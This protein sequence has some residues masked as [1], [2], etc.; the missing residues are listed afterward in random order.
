MA[1]I[2]GLDSNADDINL[3]GESTGFFDSLTVT[4][5]GVG[6]AT[7]SST[8]A[9]DVSG[10]VNTNGGFYTNGT[11]VKGLSQ[12]VT[13]VTTNNYYVTWDDVGIIIIDS[14]ITTIDA[15]WLPEV[16]SP[17]QY[18]L[19]FTF[20]FIAPQNTSGAINC[21]NNPITGLTQN[22]WWGRLF[23]V[24]F[25]MNYGGEENQIVINFT[26]ISNTYGSANP[27]WITN[28]QVDEYEASIFH[29]GTRAFTRN[30]P[31]S[32]KPAIVLTNDAQFSI[33]TNAF[34]T[35]A[36]TNVSATEFSYLNG[37]SSNIQSQI[38]AITASS[39]PDIEVTNNNTNATYYPVFTDNFGT[40][41]IAYIDK[42][43]TPFSI[44][45]NKGNM[46]LANTIK[47]DSSFNSTIGAYESKIGIG[48]EA[49]ITNQ[50]IDTLAL[51]SY[52]GSINQHQGS[53][54]IGNSAGY[55]NQGGQCVALGNF[56]GAY[57]QA[58][59]SVCI[60]SN[61]G[62]GSSG[63]SGSGTDSII[64]NAGVASPLNNTKS[65]ALF[66]NPIADSTTDT[67]NQMVTYNAT[68]K[69]VCRQSGLTID[70]TQNQLTV[71]TF[72]ANGTQIAP[73]I[74]NQYFALPTQA[75]NAFTLYP[76]PYT[77]VIA[78]SW[79]V[80]T[81]SP[82]Y[83]FIAICKGTTTYNSSRVF[84]PIPSRN[85]YL[86]FQFS[87]SPTPASVTIS[88]DITFPST[89]DYLLTY[90][91]NGTTNN[92]SGATETLNASISGTNQNAILT[93]TVWCL[94]KML[95][96]VTNISAPITLTFTCSTTA[97]TLRRVCI[98]GVIITKCVGV[99]VSDGGIT[100]NQLLEYTGINT[101][102]IFNQTGN[103]INYGRT[104]LFG[105]LELYARYAPSTTLL[106]DS[107]YGTLPTTTGGRVIA[108]GNSNILS[109]LHLQDVIS[110]GVE[111]CQNVGVGTGSNASY[112]GANSSI[113][114]IGY[115][116]L[117]AFNGL[118][119]TSSSSLH[120]IF[121]GY[122]AGRTITIPTGSVRY[123]ACVGTSVLNGRPLSTNIQYNALFGHNIMGTTAAASTTI[124]YNS[125]FGNDSFKLAR[126]ESN[127]SVGYNNFN[128][129]TS[130]SSYNN[131][132]F[133]RSVCNN[134]TGVFD[135]QNCTFI[136]AYSD[137]P[138]AGVYLN[139]TCIGYAS[140]IEFS[141][142][143]F[144]GT[145]AEMTYAKGGLNIPVTRNLVLEGEL[146]VD[147][148][149]VAPN[150]LSFLSQVAANQIPTSAISGYGTFG[151]AATFNDTATFNGATT[152]FN[153]ATTFIL[154]TT[155]TD[156]ATFNLDL[157]ANGFVSF[158]NTVNFEAT[159]T[160]GADGYTI[161]PTQLAFLSQVSYFRLATTAIEDCSTRFPTTA[162]SL[163]FFGYLAGNTQYTVPTTGV[164]NVAIGTETLMDNDAGDYNTAVGS[165]AGRQHET[166]D[167]CTYVGYSAGAVQTGSNVTIV[168]ANSCTTQTS[169]PNATIIGQGNSVA[170]GNTNAVILGKGNTI[171][172]NNCGIIGY[173]ITNNTAN[174]IIIGNTSQ[175]VEIGGNLLTNNE[176]VNEAG[177][178]ITAATTIPD[179]KF[180]PYYGIKNGA[181]AFTI[182]LPT[183]TADRVGTSIK[184]RRVLGATLS[185]VITFNC[186]T[187]TVLFAA[188]SVTAQASI[189]MLGGSASRDFV[190]LSDGG[191][192]YGWYVLS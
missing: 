149:Y 33:E 190:C 82:T 150:Q 8:Y 76:S 176:Y 5:L 63:V 95:F 186:A 78:A 139:S 31:A 167:Y 43:T 9:I 44:N 14:R 173:G 46:N 183:A 97:T 64:I 49:G 67:A 108:I 21:Y 166:G 93:E 30:F 61:A 42:T 126:G 11:L 59:G 131:C 39:T 60:G 41:Q 152:T 48:A 115:A 104:L 111:T 174:T 52:A 90:Y 138:V 96:R 155:F 13:Y 77:A 170:D 180:Y 145:A 25:I 160:I 124:Q 66:I 50:E 37:A 36:G 16:T 73:T 121:I 103:F 175:T 154:T 141:D 3:S 24:V 106:N 54:A 130:G 147:S 142:A 120:N 99:N 84:F 133:G 88:Q 35:S 1:N 162:R 164:H 29:G 182:T 119:S 32:G 38:N 171:S 56:A 153:S 83:V 181:T 87:S 45:P 191:T 109:G 163:T 7:P 107:T 192:N 168:G 128:F 65:N 101:R 18:G 159:S 19:T 185:T 144:L 143:I 53:I 158:N 72:Q 71:G 157:I 184:F 4:S 105:G 98:Y 51:G 86:A 151:A 28:Y 22:M 169:I 100:N 179:T 69:E 117:R 187:G 136:G 137:V 140:Q 74:L 81:A 165:N 116:C 94:Q 102:N 34:F 114:A 148:V 15:I 156:D 62:A 47:I 91:A 57:L 110:I 129:N 55:E 75:N 172:G 161:T 112:A 189:T 26:A 23:G 127:T 118:A 40:A 188:S 113:I 58:E 146:L 27:S 6:G 79:N 85:T 125:V 80:V 89:G 134:Q 70:S 17:S 123:N 177:N 12:K 122:E 2:Q 92:Y 132:F 20:Y 68:T 135:I 10:N 178:V